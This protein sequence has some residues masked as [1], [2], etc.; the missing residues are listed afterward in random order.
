MSLDTLLEAAKFL[1]SSSTKGTSKDDS[2]IARVP[3]ST[4]FHTERR[5]AISECETMERRRRPGG[6][7]TR[8]THNKLEKNR[9]AHLKECFDILKREVPSLEDKKTSNL[10]ILRSALKH[11]QVLK[12]R[13]RDYEAERDLLKIT[14]NRIKQRLCVLKKEIVIKQELVKKSQQNGVISM[15]SQPPADHVP[16]VNLQGIEGQAS[17]VSVA[18]QTSFTSGEESDTDLA[19]VSTANMTKAENQQIVTV[20]IGMEDHSVAVKKE[21]LMD[22][23]DEDVD[24]E[25]E[26]TDDNTEDVDALI[27]NEVR[28]NSTEDKAEEA[29]TT[30]GSSNKR[31]AVSDDN[32][33]KV[34]AKKSNIQ[35]CAR[36]SC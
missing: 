25:G 22:D 19:G 21:V 9:R 14:N 3:R 18:T 8:E 15:S 1:E 36:I 32:D 28:K 34:E 7:G 31:K 23:E 12:K 24:V 35:C 20:S 27:K 17:P 2:A 13:E 10:N 11:I 26:I 29:R 6:A 5:R 30:P 4:P 16:T 33:N